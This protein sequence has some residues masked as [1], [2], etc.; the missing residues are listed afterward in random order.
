MRAI[1]DMSVLITG[2]GSGIGAGC[3]EL[4]VEGGAKVTITGRLLQQSHTA[5]NSMCSSTTPAACIDKRWE[6]TQR[7]F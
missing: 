4:F 6:H 7:S 3:A 1:K 2:G 5:V